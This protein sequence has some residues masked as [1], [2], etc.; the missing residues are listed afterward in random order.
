MNHRDKIAILGYGLE[1]KAMLKYL[2]KHE[3]GN[4]TVCDRN[5]D[6]PDKMPDGVS[7]RLGKD[8]L[9]GLLDFNVIFRSPG[10]PF[11]D[12][13]V[14][15]SSKNGVHVTSVIDYFMDQCPCSVVGVT[16][17]KGKGT[18]CSLIF[19]ML[20]KSGRK[21]DKDVFLGGNIGRP[22]IEF[23]DKLKV[24]N[25]VVLELSSFQLQDL[26]KSPRY[27]VILNTTT[28]HLDYH[29]DRDEYL[30]AKEKILAGQHE[31]SIAVLNMDYEYSKY[32]AP[33][34]KGKVFWMSTF[35]AVSDGAYVKNGVIFYSRSGE[36]E[37]IA[38]VSDV[39]LIGSHNLE[40]IMSAVVIAKELG[41]SG[42]ECEAVIKSFENLPHRLE[43]V[44]EVGGVK[45]Y[46]DS[47][48][49]T[50]ETSMAAVDS[51][52]EPTVLIAGGFD[53][54]LDYSEWAVRILTK[55][56]LHTVILVGNTA[57]KME[58]ALISA[59]DKLGEAEGFPT[60]ILRRGN[61]EEAVVDA[62]AECSEGSVVVM[63][64]A[65]SSFD[66]YKDYKERGAE[67]IRN[68]KKLR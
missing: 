60:K 24:N 32:Y 65:A 67:F 55:P 10:I 16:G 23:L 17:T 45:F 58:N 48:S 53:K 62:F 63:S 59:E 19:E 36:S 14:Q 47:Y 52:D 37:K 61:L 42:R 12:G 51:F 41:V 44:R 35:S 20:K 4:I 54:G 56:N 64:P 38:K 5:V 8:Y 18:T 50:P 46:N 2:L 43:F 15:A 39:K 57:D 40:N 21:E 22:P 9:D 29:A 13:N 33:L 66:L 28:D 7:A 25:I 30:H 34:T 11:L 26:K 6:L 49:T 31:D 1:G 3:F 27:A 68:V